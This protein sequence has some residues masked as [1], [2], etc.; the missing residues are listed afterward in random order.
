MLQSSR[1]VSVGA[2]LVAALGLLLV[3]GSLSTAAGAPLAQTPPPTPGAATAAS[4]A[5]TATPLSLQTLSQIQPGLSTY[6][7]E[8]AQRFGVM[9]FAAQ[10]SNPDLAAFEAR[11][12]QEVLQHGAVRQNA[13]RQQAITAFNTNFMEPLITAAQSGNQTQFQASY[14]AAIQGCNSC[15]AA[16]T[17][18]TINKPF[19]F[20]KIQVPKNSPEEVYAYSP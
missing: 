20:V 8:T 14:S 16:Q 6:M 2:G 17:Y 11:E 15:H 9:W 3:V 4:P 5:P 13:A 1:V 12:A 19:S 10:Q 18:T 7:M